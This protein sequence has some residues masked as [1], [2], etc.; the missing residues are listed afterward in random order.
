TFVVAANSGGSRTGT[1]TI[2]GHI[3]TVTQ[4][5]NE[6]LPPD[7]SYSIAPPSR[8]IGDG[9]GSIDVTVTTKTDC[10]WTAVSGSAWISVAS[11]SA[12]AGL[13]RVG[14]SVAPNT[15][16]NTRTGTVTIAGSVFTVQ[17]AG[18]TPTCSFSIAPPS[19][20]VAASGGSQTV[21]VTTAAG[22]AWTAVSS[23]SWI[24]IG[25]AG[26]GEGNGTVQL[27]VDPNTSSSPRS[28]TVTIAGRIFTVQQA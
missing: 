24:D 15:S 2:A 28:G 8:S 11:G 25:S 4:G 6:T 7:C 14:L 5:G 26:R 16:V 19:A 22:C 27:R 23:V 10:A 21:T 3:I 13:G 18:V 9:G 1:L 17:Q 20:S 12:G